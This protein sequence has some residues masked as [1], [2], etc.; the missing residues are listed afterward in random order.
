MLAPLAFVDALQSLTLALLGRALADI[1]IQLSLVGEFLAEVCDPVTLIGDA[2]SF[3]GDPL[4]PR[5]L[6]LAQP[7]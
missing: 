7:D 5:E 6:T 1:R 3:V 2:V 4:A